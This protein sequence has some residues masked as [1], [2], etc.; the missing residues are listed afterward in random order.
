[1]KKTKL[2]NRLY[3]VPTGKYHEECETQNSLIL[4]S[5]TLKT[6]GM[7]SML[8]SVTST[9][10]TWLSNGLMVTSGIFV[11]ASAASVLY[12]ILYVLL[13]PKLF[14]EFPVDF[15]YDYSTTKGRPSAEA[16]IDLSRSSFQQASLRSCS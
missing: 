16:L 9:A 10:K 4:F 3:N 1:M 2:R 12:S 13:I 14:F 11:S 6:R 7:L 8:S 15:H 5:I